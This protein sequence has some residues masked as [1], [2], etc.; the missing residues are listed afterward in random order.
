MKALVVPLA[1]TTR[2]E[3][4]RRN[5]VMTLIAGVMLVSMICL[6]MGTSPANCAVLGIPMILYTQ[7]RYLRHGDYKCQGL[8]LRDMKKTSEYKMRDF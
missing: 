3:V 4:I 7:Y 8:L 5:K 6:L 1:M 2:M